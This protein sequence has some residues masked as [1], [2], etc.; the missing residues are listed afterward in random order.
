MLTTDARVA[1]AI[2]TVFNS[3]LYPAMKDQ[4]TI[5]QEEIANLSGISR[6]RCNAALN[7]LKQAGLIRTEYG[8]VKV[9]DLPRLVQFAG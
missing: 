3:R 5:S 4:L 7:H 9:V 8:S 6:P 2:A 1:Q